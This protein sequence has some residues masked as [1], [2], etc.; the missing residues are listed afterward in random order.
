MNFLIE[1]TTPEHAMKPDANP[2][3]RPARPEIQPTGNPSFAWT[4]ARSLLAC[5]HLFTLGI[6]AAPNR[7]ILE[8]LPRHLGFGEKPPAPKLPEVPLAEFLD[9]APLKIR[10]AAC[11]DG[12]VTVTELL[13]LAALA[14]KYQPKTI[15]EIGTFDGRT[16]LNL[17]ANAPEARVHTLDL[18]PGHATALP[19]KGGDDKYID[20]SESGA[21]FRGTD[22]QARIVQH[23]GDSATFDFAPFAGN[24]DMVFVDGAHSDAYVRRDSENALKLLRGG[25]GVI[26]WHDYGTRQV[27]EALDDL[28]AK[29]PAFR[30]MRRV[31]ETGLAVLIL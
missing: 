1:P 16:T 9:G 22:C 10:E 27:T 15:F 13:V 21:R 17:A 25:R 19:V 8:R 24:I 31:Q 3:P 5:A 12:N 30:G 20:K 4:Y 26:A 23:Y 11:V 2:P 28:H 7:R 18:P 6:L 14:K 29:I